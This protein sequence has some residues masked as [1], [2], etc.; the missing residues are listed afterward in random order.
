MMFSTL[1]PSAATI[2]IARTNSGKA[3][4][5]S[6]SHMAMRSTQPPKNPATLPSAL[7]T[8]MASTTALVAMNR[9][10]RVA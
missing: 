10:R 1:L 7:P 8:T 9:S 2:P 4:M 5:V 6:T 3:M